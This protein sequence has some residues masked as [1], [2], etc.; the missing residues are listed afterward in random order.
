VRDQFKRYRITILLCSQRLHKL[1]AKREK[2]NAEIERISELLTANANFLPAEQ[3]AEQ[4]LQLEQLVAD[5]PGFTDSVRQVLRANRWAEATPIAV[6]DMLAKAGFNLSAY[7]NPLAS[8][9]TILKRLAERGEVT[10]S[11]NDGQVCY[12][13]KADAPRK[14][15]GIYRGA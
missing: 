14:E 8:I 7:T 11:M 15:P 2:L 1:V 6:R 5:P 3:K 9:H 12:R 10:A 13:W 4:L